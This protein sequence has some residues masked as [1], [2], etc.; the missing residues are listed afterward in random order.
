M[1]ELKR[2]FRLER[3]AVS[4]LSSPRQQSLGLGAMRW[5]PEDAANDQ[6]ASDR[7]K[8]KDREVNCIENQEHTAESLALSTARTTRA[9][10][11]LH[12]HIRSLSLS[13]TRWKIGQRRKKFRFKQHDENLLATGRL[14]HGVCRLPPGFAL[15]IV[16]PN[17]IVLELKD[18]D[19][20]Q[21][22]SSYSLFKGLAAIAHLVSTSILLYKTQG[23]QFR[24]YRLSAFG[25]IVIPY[26]F[27]SLVNLMGSILTPD[28]PALYM[29]KTEIM[30]EAERR[31]GA[32]FEG[33]VGRLGDP[34][35][36]I[37][38]V[39]RC[40]KQKSRRHEIPICDSNRDTR[41]EEDA[42]QVRTAYDYSRYQHVRIPASHTYLGKDTLP[43]RPSTQLRTRSFPVRL[44]DFI[45][46]EMPFLLRSVFPYTEN[47]DSEVYFNEALILCWM[48]ASHI[49]GRLLPVLDNCIEPP[50]KA[51]RKWSWKTLGMIS[52]T[53]FVVTTCGFAIRQFVFTGQMIM[54]YGHCVL[55][56]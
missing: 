46:F 17:S 38:A 10:L 21:I 50:W 48:V 37:N 13:T 1:D 28:Y 41:R 36:P 42:A 3:G 25:L 49:A 29:V 7:L 52:A 34:E 51:M 31:E 32:C 26:S 45:V 14:V 54:D 8:G 6:Q 20:F 23:D 33:V 12:R 43:R 22:G 35:R 44:E 53:A 4:L 27:M 30:I 9:G 5:P 11:D 55:V 39:F 56:D 40:S 15:S 18:D 24:R 19:H 47:L 16:D 2:N